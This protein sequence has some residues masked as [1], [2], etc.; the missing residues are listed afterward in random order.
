MKNIPIIN[1]IKDYVGEGV[2]PFSMP[3][4]KMGR[5]FSDIK[6]ILLNGDLTEVDGL[7][8]LHKPEGIIKEAEDKLTSLYKSKKSY[9]LVNGSTCGN[10]I[11]IFSSFNE[12]DK[13]LVERNCHRSI[14]NGIIMRKLEPIF[15]KNI[16]SPKL[17]APIGL[18]INHLEQ[19]LKEHDDIK[20]IILTYPNYYGIGI[21]LEYIINTCKSYGLKVLV[22]SAHG[23]HFGFNKKLPTSVQNFKP[24]MV[25]MSAHKTLPSLTQTAWLHVNNDMDL[26]KVE[27]YKGIFMSTSPSY[28]F[29]MS[30]DYSR[31]FLENKAAIAYDE[32]FK[33]VGE[34]KNKVRSLDYIKIVDKEFL[35]DSIKQKQLL[36]KQSSIEI[37]E[38]RIVINLIEGFNGNRLLEYLRENK[39]QCEMS[40]HKNVVLI[41]ST[42]NTREDFNILAEILLR[43]DKECLREDDVNFY[44]SDIP[45]MAILPYKVVDKEKEVINLE[46]S[47]ERIV[48]DNIIP[49]PPGVPILI[50]GEVIEEEH[51][52]IISTCVNN[53][54]TVMGVDNNKIRVVKN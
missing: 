21:G 20:G 10:L 50:A 52:N 19:M 31:E 48:A 17:K 33:L 42:F 29:M 5:A 44:T 45:K 11:M 36:N 6:E 51:I 30:L 23:A 40:E 37:D 24:D 34:F 43:C 41:P 25:V 26:E 22:D 18:D 49:Y 39:I 35:K 53:N 13:V 46:K 38:S 16:F 7:D 8:N 1:G 3:G 47:I 27:F 2:I 28:M 4:H 9:L 54:I 32:L 14:M 15:I 12:G